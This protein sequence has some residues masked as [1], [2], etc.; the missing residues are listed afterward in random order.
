MRQCW[1]YDGAVRLVVAPELP[2]VKNYFEQ[3]DQSL[4]AANDEV[5]R[6]RIVSCRFELCA[7]IFGFFFC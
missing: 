3:A 7:H 2:G 5:R 4:R 6:D 1:F